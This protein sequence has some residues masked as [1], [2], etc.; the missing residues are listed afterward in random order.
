MTAV[1]YSSMSRIW[2]LRQDTEFDCLFS[3][4]HGS[5]DYG[6]YNVVCLFISA[7]ILKLME[8]KFIRGRLHT[9]VLRADLFL[10][11]ISI[12]ELREIL[13]LTLANS[14]KTFRTDSIVLFCRSTILG[15]STE[16]SSS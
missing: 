5:H 8:I 13:N 15:L 10:I 11:K 2:T 6:A 9:A 7:R 14:I 1:K 12:E 3:E 4:D 16:G